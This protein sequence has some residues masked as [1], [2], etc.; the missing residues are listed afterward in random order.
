VGERADVPGAW[1][2]PQGGVDPGENSD[3]ALSREMFEEVG[4][5]NFEVLSKPDQLVTYRFPEDLAG[6]MAE[7]YEGQ[8]QQWYLLRNLG[9]Q[10][11]DP[12]NGDGEFS[13]FK[14]I[15]P[16]ASVDGIVDWK[17]DAYRQGL[18]LLGLL[19]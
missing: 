8:E 10:E 7:V 12:K 1:Q 2:F 4:I 6:Q 18:K 19:E 17:R 5:Q 14:W 13:R 16:K 9:N 11:L 15:S 3:E